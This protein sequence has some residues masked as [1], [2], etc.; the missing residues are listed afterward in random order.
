[1][2]WVEWVAAVAGVVSVY[3][4]AR[5]NIWSWP[6]GIVNVGLYIFVFYSTGLYA[7][8][9]LQVVYL[10]ISIYGWYHWLYGGADH[11]ALRVSRATPRTWAVAASIAVVFWFALATYTSRLPGVSLP[12]LDSALTTLSLVAQWMMT[13]KHVENWI[14]WIIADLVYIPMFIYKD[15]Y[16]TAGQ[17]AVFLVLATMGFI[18]WRRSYRA[19]RTVTPAATPA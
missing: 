8:T 12:Y 5:Q 2:G 11:S 15:L 14:L 19:D 18:Q 7:E 13:R 1:V 16:P 10:V 4:S 17:Y 3:L 9:G 6:T